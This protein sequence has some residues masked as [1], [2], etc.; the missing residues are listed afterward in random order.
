MYFGYHNNLGEKL[1]NR[2]YVNLLMFNS[3]TV[4]KI[5]VTQFGL[6]VYH[7]LSLKENLI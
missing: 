7:K 5:L 1:K 4:L 3:M 6:Y 2:C